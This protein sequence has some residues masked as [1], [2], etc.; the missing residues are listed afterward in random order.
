MPPRAALPQAL[1]PPPRTISA[2]AR[3]SR[4][5]LVQVTQPPKGSLRRMPSDEDERATGAVGTEVTERD[6]LGRRVGGETAGAAEQAEGGR[7]LKGVVG[8]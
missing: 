2:E 5:A 8:P 6:P 7:G 3:L 1:V 4:G